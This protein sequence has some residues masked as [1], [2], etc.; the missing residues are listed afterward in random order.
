M[1]SYAFISPVTASPRA[2]HLRPEL[3]WPTMPKPAL[4]AI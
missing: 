4:A 3:D 1:L 2:A